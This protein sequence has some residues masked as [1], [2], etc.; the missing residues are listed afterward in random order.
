MHLRGPL[1][2]CISPEISCLPVFV[3]EREKKKFLKHSMVTLL[4]IKIY[5]ICEISNLKRFF[6]S[7]NA[8]LCPMNWLL[9]A[10]ALVWVILRC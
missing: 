3:L 5:T 8:R 4:K 2:I 1:Y 10:R 7:E 6:L 9:Q